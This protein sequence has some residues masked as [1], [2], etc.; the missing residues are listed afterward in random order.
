VLPDNKHQLAG[1]ALYLRQAEIFITPEF[2]K[3]SGGLLSRT[4]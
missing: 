1:A 4:R 3:I 2:E